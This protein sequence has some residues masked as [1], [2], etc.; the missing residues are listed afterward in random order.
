MS[1]KEAR[2]RIEAMT[3]CRSLSQV[4]AFMKRHDLRYIKMGHIPAK[5][6]AVK[7]A[8]WLSTTFEPVK[9]QAQNRECHLLFMDAS[10]FILQPFICALW[11]T[12]RLFVISPKA[13]RVVTG[14]MCRE[15]FHIYFTQDGVRLCL[16]YPHQK[17]SSSR[18]TTPPLP[19][20]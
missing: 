18:K 14:L 4:R 2:S 8:E 11:C 9:K 16:H 12:A 13:R 10:H 6:D 7:Q 5:A 20:G 19:T 17:S 1:T 3:G 15:L